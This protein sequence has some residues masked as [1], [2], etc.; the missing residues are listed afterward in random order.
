VGLSDKQRGV[1]VGMAAGAVVALA[2][3]ILGV[4]LNPLGYP[5]EVATRARLELAAAAMLVPASFV[6]VSIARLAKHRFFSPADIDGGGLSEGTARAR[7]LQSLLQNTLEQAVL[8]TLVYAAWSLLAPGSWLSAVPLCAIAFALGRV[9]FFVGYAK[10]APSR[11][12]GFT[13]T[14][15]PTLVMLACVLGRWIG[16]LLGFW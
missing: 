16:L 6:A 1:L 3:V 12:F 2:L 11:A 8:A 13:L 7:V 4:T 10:G 14:F 15:Y 9:L 5:G